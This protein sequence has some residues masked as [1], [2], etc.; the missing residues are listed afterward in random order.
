MTSARRRHRAPALGAPR[1]VSGR[2]GPAS[3]CWFKA[4]LPKGLYARALLIIIAPMVILQ[5]VVAFVFMERHWNLVTR[6]L[7]AG[8]GAA[9]S[10]R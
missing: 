5:S 7:S 1:S 4:L 10:R 2:L 8:G 9:I 3:T 6:H